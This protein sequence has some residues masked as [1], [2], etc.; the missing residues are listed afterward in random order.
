MPQRQPS[1]CLSICPHCRPPPSPDT[2]VHPQTAPPVGWNR[3]GSGLLPAAPKPTARWPR[4]SPLSVTENG[5]PKVTGFRT[6]PLRTGCLG[7][8]NT[9][10]DLRQR[11]KQ[12]GLS[13]PFQKQVRDPPGTEAL[14]AWR[15]KRPYLQEGGLG[16]AERVLRAPAGH[17]PE[18]PHSVQLLAP[19][20]PSSANPEDTQV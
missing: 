12:E 6:S 11:R 13:D 14:H 9:R 4:P 15:K 10:R 3:Q 1:V 19:S 18:L 8:L 5:G 16:R 17:H 2:Q 20:S 7:M